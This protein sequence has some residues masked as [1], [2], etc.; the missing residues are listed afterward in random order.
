MKG[1]KET[2]ENQKIEKRKTDGVDHD[3]LRCAH[4]GGWSCRTDGVRVCRR[5]KPRLP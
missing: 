4:Y 5:C 3:T 2:N 1:K